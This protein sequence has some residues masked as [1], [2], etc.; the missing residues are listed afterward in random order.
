LTRGWGNQHNLG[1]IHLTVKKAMLNG[2][3]AIEVWIW[4]YIGKIIGKRGI[5]GYDV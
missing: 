1:F 5:V 3:V 2:L 4:F